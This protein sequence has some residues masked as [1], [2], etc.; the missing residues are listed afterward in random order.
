MRC[1]IC[2]ALEDTE[3]VNGGQTLEYSKRQLEEPVCL[4]KVV[5]IAVRRDTGCRQLGGRQANLV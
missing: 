4:I 1:K 5:E 2:L 3:T